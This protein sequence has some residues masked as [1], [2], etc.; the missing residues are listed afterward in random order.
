MPKKLLADKVEE[1]LH[2]LI[3]NGGAIV[4]TA[5][6]TGVDPATVASIK[7][8]SLAAFE[9]QQLQKGREFVNLG[10]K[11]II[12]LI[13]SSAFQEKIDTADLKDVTD[14]ISKMVDKLSSYQK[15]L[16]IQALDASDLDDEIEGSTKHRKSEEIADLQLIE[17]D[18]DPREG[19][20]KSLTEADEAP[21]KDGNESDN[22]WP[23][24]QTPLA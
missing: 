2:T 21:L 18:V 22:T 20:V 12:K 7:R 9:T 4:K 6:E 8:K 19:E 11:F 14:F 1:I 13:K 16:G 17:P 24:T 10:H 3:K 5:E 15:L 23:D